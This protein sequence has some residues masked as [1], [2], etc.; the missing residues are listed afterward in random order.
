[1]HKPSS[2]HLV[3]PLPLAQKLCKLEE[4]RCGANITVCKPLAGVGSVFERVRHR[5]ITNISR[6]FD[7]L[8]LQRASQG[9]IVH[10]QP[11]E[12]SED[13]ALKIIIDMRVTIQG[14]FICQVLP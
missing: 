3:E 12:C 2:Y 11:S 4:R 1:M 10:T 9:E 6:T 13:V 7:Q 5:T 8:D 14:F